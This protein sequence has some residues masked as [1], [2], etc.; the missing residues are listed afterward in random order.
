M[1]AE[2]ARKTPAD[3]PDDPTATTMT[4]ASP[5]NATTSGTAW[6]SGGRNSL[7]ACRVCDHR[8]IARYVTANASVAII[9]IQP[10]T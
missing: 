8:N 9:P 6:F 5:N 4:A 2:T 1:T 7:C 3:S 10:R